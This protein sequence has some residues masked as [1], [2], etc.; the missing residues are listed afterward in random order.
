MLCPENVPS[1]GILERG[2]KKN[3]NMGRLVWAFRKPDKT[4]LEIPWCQV[5]LYSPCCCR[6]YV[7]T[8]ASWLPRLREVLP[9]VLFV[10]SFF[11]C[12]LRDTAVSLSLWEKKKV[13]SRILPPCFS[14]GRSEP[15]PAFC[16]VGRSP[17]R[18]DEVIAFL[19][20]P[21]LRNL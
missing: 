15:V 6:C 14:H 3:N 11:D 5:A 16:L 7:L 2:R 8:T 19:Q 1:S 9:P 18:S 17:G 10:L 12:T 4:L 20:R 13:D 21:V